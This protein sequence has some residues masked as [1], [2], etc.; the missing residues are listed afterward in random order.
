MPVKLAGLGCSSTPRE[1][2]A[3]K[4][5]S[6]QKPGGTIRRYI[7]PGLHFT[8]KHFF[9]QAGGPGKEED[10]RPMD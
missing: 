7:Q 5:T 2:G 8:T 10:K 1:G 6:S 4:G 3:K 9:G